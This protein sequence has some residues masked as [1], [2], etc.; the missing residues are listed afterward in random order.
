MSEETKPTIY[1]QFPATEEIINASLQ[2]LHEKCD[3][4]REALYPFAMAVHPGTD[5]LGY[6]LSSTER[7]SLD[8]SLKAREVYEATK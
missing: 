2:V 5:G 8:S 3:A 1:V 7:V 4:L 6:T